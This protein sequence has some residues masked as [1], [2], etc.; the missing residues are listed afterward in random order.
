MSMDDQTPP[1]GTIRSWL[2][3]RAS[4]IG[5]R[6]AYLFFDGEAALTW[7]SLRDRARKLAENLTAQ[8][9]DKGASVAILQPNGRE[10]IECLYGVLYGGFR[11][12]VIN[13]VAG[14]EAIG[15]ALGHCDARIAFVGDAQ[16]DLFDRVR[17]K[18]MTRYSASRFDKAPDLH[19]LGP[20]DDALL[21]YTSG[22]TGRP[23]GVVH[24][25]FSLLAG[26]WT[27]TVAH[28]LTPADR[29][30]CVLPIYHING[31]CVTVLSALVSGGSLAVA[32]KFSTRKFWDQCQSAKTTWF[33]VVPTI[34]SHLLHSELTPAQET[35]ARLRFGRSASSPLAPDVQTAF[36]TR[37]EVPIVETMGLTETAAQ[38]LS[39]PLPPGVRKIGSPGKAY[40]NEACILSAD[41][42]PL[43]PNT[44]GEIAV[45]GPNLMREY[46]KNPDATRATFTPDGWLRTGDLG[47]MDEDGYFFVTGRLKE[48]II[49]G[50]ENIAPREIDEAL[51]SHP[52]VIE[53]AAFARPCKTYGERV[54]AAVKLR[55]GSSVSSDQL[56]A[57][58]VQRLGAFKSPDKV[59]LLQDLPKG[60]SGKIQRIKL[61]VLTQ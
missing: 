8:G 1:G 22:T 19:A 20:D 26:G 34:I 46:L 16:A 42:T 57:I 24:S 35:R 6:D 31:L 32:E 52:D 9:L 15:Y 12:T 48:L 36:E 61:P 55:T 5:D 13:L 7:S 50:G 59:H 51:Y 23:K 41:L 4:T 3:E 27:P 56:I 37:F 54:E 38:I 10:A 60:P 33:S 40:G 44:K 17:P 58:C 28:K 14:D 18:E 25:H 39:N 43:P 49:K 2:D 47:H 29:G 11:A 45:R 53:A 21:M 30:L